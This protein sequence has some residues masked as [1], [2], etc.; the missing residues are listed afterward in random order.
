MAVVHT[1]KGRLP[2]NRARL[3][4]E[5]VDVLLWRWERGKVAGTEEVRTLDLLL[6]DVNCAEADL[7]RTLGELAFGVHGRAGD[8]DELA[9][10]PEYDLQEALRALHPNKSWDWA[11]E[12]IGA[13]KLRAGILLERDR[14]LYTFPHRTFQ[15]YLA[16]AY[17]AVQGD[18]VEQAVDLTRAGHFW[19]E[20]ILLAVGYLI[21]SHSDH[22]RPLALAGGLCPDSAPNTETGWRRVWLAGEVIGEMGVSRAEKAAGGPR[23]VNTARE[24]LKALMEAGALTPTERVAA[25]NTLAEIG[26]PRFDPEYWYLPVDP[27]RGFKKIEAGTFRMGSDKEHDPNTYGDETPR[28]QVTLPDYLI[29]RYPV[30]VAQFRAFVEDSGYQPGNSNCLRGVANHPVVRIS[31]HEANRYCQWLTERLKADEKCPEPLAGL[32]Q[33]RGWVIRLP[34][35]AEWE[36]AARGDDGRIYPWG[37]EPDPGKANYGDTG[38]RTTS[39]VGC[40]P[41]GAGPHEIFDMAGNV[42]EWTGSVMADYPYK[43]GASKHEENTA[44]GSCRR[45]LRGGSFDGYRLLVRCA[46]RDRDYPLNWLDDIGFR[47]A[48]APGKTPLGL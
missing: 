4:E 25:G 1:H 39:P 11:H 42:W 32:I 41:D 16:A 47:L 18:F 43:P 28:H 3:Y 6:Q 37:R 30:T 12:V 7:K 17:L 46:A 21:F 35:E 45:V 9:D 33:E 34:S 10:I 31:W 26:D 23:L 22:Y 48:C 14:G 19:R 29:A 40:F 13:M 5:A 27:M 24:M 15:E 36:K 2:E 38:I 20:V 44:E 8:G